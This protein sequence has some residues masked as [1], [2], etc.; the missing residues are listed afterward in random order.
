[1][2]PSPERRNERRTLELPK[3]PKQKSKKK[4]KKLEQRPLLKRLKLDV[5]PPKVWPRQRWRRTE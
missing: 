3:S 1:M 2:L 5:P 4:M